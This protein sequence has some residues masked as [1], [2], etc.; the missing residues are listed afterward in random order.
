MKDAFPIMQGSAAIT[1][2]AWGQF[3]AGG[4]NTFV[5]V[6]GAIILILTIWNKI[7]EIKQRRKE[8]RD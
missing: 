5:A 2:P 7:L 3:L 4:W 6:M 8:M 1:F